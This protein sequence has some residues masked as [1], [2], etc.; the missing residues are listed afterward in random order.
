MS[1]HTREMATAQEAFQAGIDAM[2]LA[3][4]H[5]PAKAKIGIDLAKDLFKSVA[6]QTKMTEAEF[7]K[8]IVKGEIRFNQVKLKAGW[9]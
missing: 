4:G 1:Q 8:A 9:V 7:L 2:K 3:W 6:M 5:P